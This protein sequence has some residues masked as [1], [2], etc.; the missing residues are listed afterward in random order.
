MILATL[1]TVRIINYA[2]INEEELTK[3]DEIVKSISDITYEIYLVQYPVIFLFQEI[4][5]ELYF[6][7][8]LNKP[9]V[10][11]D[12]TLFDKAFKVDLS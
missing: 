10:I 4:E 2:T 1:I 8:F 5:M 7:N 9:K 12:Q 6:K 3:K 11:F